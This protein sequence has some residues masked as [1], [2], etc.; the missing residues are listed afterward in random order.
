MQYRIFVE[1]LAGTRG[2]IRDNRANRPSYAAFDVTAADICTVAPDL[3]FAKVV[4][5][6]FLAYC[7]KYDTSGL[8][9]TNPRKIIFKKVLAGSIASH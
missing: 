5:Q 2:Y 4:K 1:T 7:E 8:G 6:A 9:F 3:A